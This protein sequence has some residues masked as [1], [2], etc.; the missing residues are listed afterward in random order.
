MLLTLA[1]K[2]RPWLRTLRRNPQRKA[3]SMEVPGAAGYLQNDEKG[4]V[5]VKR[6]NVTHF[7][8]DLND[9]VGGS[10]GETTPE[11]SLLRCGQKLARKREEREMYHL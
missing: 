9:K 10:E 4:C 6:I 2:H 7:E 5:A 11:P 8:F 3:I 1:A